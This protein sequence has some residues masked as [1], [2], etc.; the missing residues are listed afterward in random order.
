MPSKQALR[1]FQS[2]LAQRLQSARSS[3]VAASWLAVEAGGKRLLFP[4][5]HAGEIF[6]WT[7]VQR[8]PYV[9][10]WFMGIANL[11]G[12]LSGV[13]DLAAFIYGQSGKT[14]AETALAQCR[15][16]AL[17]PLLDTNCALLVDRLL[18]LRTTDAF[19]S[20]APAAQDAPA[21]FGH[22]H[23]DLDGGTWQEINLQTLSQHPAFLGIG[24]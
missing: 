21:Y 6:S 15:I 20:S 11:R 13:V 22:V 10:P 16:V 1:D 17:N 12:G 14:R 3:G 9:Q 4:L 2:R 19:A 23:T 8:V 24:I 5:S 7:D 18:G